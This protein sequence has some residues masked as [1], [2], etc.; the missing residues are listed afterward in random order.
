M[1]IQEMT[2]EQLIYDLTEAQERDVS[3][4]HLVRIY[5][6]EVMRRFKKGELSQ[7][8]VTSI[9]VKKGGIF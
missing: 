5:Q 3:N 2:L 1:K 6:N 9:D 4:K 7:M 8:P